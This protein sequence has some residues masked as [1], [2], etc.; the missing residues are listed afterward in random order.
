MDFV[1]YLLRVLVW[2]TFLP[3]LLWVCWSILDRSFEWRYLASIVLPLSL[4]AAYR[5]IY[6]RVGA[7]LTD[8]E[9]LRRYQQSLD[10]GSRYIRAKSRNQWRDNRWK[11]IQPRETEDEQ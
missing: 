7:A 8:E 6:K 11:S 1:A 10:R 3:W 5:T 9:R 4:W 2:A